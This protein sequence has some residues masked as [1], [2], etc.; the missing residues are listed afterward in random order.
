MIAQ[1]PL[2]A[3][4]L[5]E[6]DEPWKARATEGIGNASSNKFDRLFDEGQKAYIRGGLAGLNGRAAAWPAS[7]GL[8]LTGH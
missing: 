2:A 8:E 7:R 3:R 5:I 1:A 6:K 4:P